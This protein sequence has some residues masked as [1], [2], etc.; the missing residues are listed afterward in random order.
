[1]NESRRNTFNKTH[2]HTPRG[3]FDSQKIYRPSGLIKQNPKLKTMFQIY[4]CTHSELDWTRRQGFPERPDCV[5][6]HF[7]CVTSLCYPLS[8]PTKQQWKQRSGF[9]RRILKHVRLLTPTSRQ[10]GWHRGSQE[11]VH[12]QGSNPVPPACGGDRQRLSGSVQH[13]HFDRQRVQLPAGRPLSLGGGERP[14]PL[15]GGQPADLVRASDLPGR[16]HR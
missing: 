15:H 5:L 13:Q 9:I 6:N 16:P 12:T 8:S 14:R 7:T 10:H 2:F 4:F 1:M 3:K 11:H